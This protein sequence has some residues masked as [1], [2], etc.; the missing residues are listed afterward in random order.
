M[1]FTDQKDQP[2]CMLNGS[3][4]A[5]WAKKVPCEFGVD[6]KLY[7]GV[8]IFPKTSIFTAECRTSSHFNR[9]EKLLNVKN[10]PK[11]QTDHRTKLGSEN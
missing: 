10:R 3:N 9:L 8:E 6:I 1:P 11:I 2:L 7:L 5:V 4:D